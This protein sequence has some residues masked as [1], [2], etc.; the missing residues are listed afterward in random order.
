MRHH[1]SEQLDLVFDELAELCV[2]V[3]IAVRQATE[4][5]LAGDGAAAER[6][7]SGD[8]D[9]DERRDRVEDRCFR[10]LSLQQPVAG[11]LRTVVAALRMGS[12]IERSGDLAV[13]VAKVARL[14]VPGVAVPDELTPVV[15]RMSEIAVDMMGRTASIV[16]ERDIAGLV[17]LRALDDEMDDLRATLLQQIVGPGWSHGV[18]PAVD[19][20][21]LSRYYERIGDH[22]VS[23]AKRVDYVITGERP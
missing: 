4:A 14:R 18:E 19:L 23:V 17:A 7:I 3:Q 10:I 15:F 13:H 6:V 12:E 8:L 16:A 21:L 5:L 11:D 9:V 20:A 2:T 1:F 22:A